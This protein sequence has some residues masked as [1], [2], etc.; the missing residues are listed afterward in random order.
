MRTNRE[1]KDEPL[2]RR[3]RPP[4]GG[5]SSGLTQAGP[6]ESGLGAVNGTPLGLLYAFRCCPLALGRVLRAGV[7]GSAMTSMSGARSESAASI[8][9]AGMVVRKTGARV[10]EE[11]PTARATSPGIAEV[12]IFVTVSKPGRCRQRQK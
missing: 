2:E 1:V 4:H 9:T 5:R 7:R 10:A 6:S 11:I 12:S 8:E 3:F